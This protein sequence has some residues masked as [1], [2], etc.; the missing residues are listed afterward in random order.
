MKTK[1]MLAATLAGLTL[2]FAAGCA[3]STPAPSA[4]KVAETTAPSASATATTPPAAASGAISITDMSGKTIQLDKPAERVVVLTASD[5]EIIY[6]LGAGS[7]VVG[8]GEYCTYPEETAKVTAVKSGSDTNIEQLIALK[9]DVI[10]M[11]TMAQTKEQIASLE[12]AGVKVIVSSAQN[13]DG[14]YTAITLIG[15][16]VGKNDEA[17]K[18]VTSMKKT[19]DELKAKVPKGSP[20]TIYFEVSPLSAGTLYTS[21]TGTFMDELASML[22][23]K[24]IFSDTKSWAQVS[25]E[26]VIQRNPEYIVT[27]SMAKAGAVNPVD[28]ILARQ[29]WE[30]IVAIKNRA[31]FNADS[32]S[33]ALMHPG[34]RLTDAAQQ[35]YNFVYGGSTPV[36]LAS[37]TK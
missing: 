12:K 25:E 2:I 5:C 13:I 14:I 1:Q 10:I 9:P 32:N 20:K 26:Q 34:P 24:N 7:T 8:R 19:F 6:A 15:Q 29:G 36:V 27:T 35:L 23:L 31:L 3:S 4:S 37:P 17:T 30:N 22:N 28:E 11:S 33:S 16:V 21:G 18:I